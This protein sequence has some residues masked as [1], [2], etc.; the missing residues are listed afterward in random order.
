MKYG[1]ETMREDPVF[2]SGEHL[3]I[4]EYNLNS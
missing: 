4:S 1:K 2:R 3:L